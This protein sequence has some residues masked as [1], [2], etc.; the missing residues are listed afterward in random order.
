MADSIYYATTAEGERLSIVDV[1]HPAFAVTVTDDELAVLSDGYVQGLSQRSTLPPQVMEALQRSQL[2]RGLFAASGTY[3]SG[4]ATYL[5][6]LGPDNLPD[7]AEEIDRRLAASFP[8]LMTRLR[9]QDMTQLLVDG[10]TTT[11]RDARDRP[12]ALVNL[13]AGVAA[14][15]WNALIVLRSAGLLEQR[16]VSVVAFDRE[17]AGSMFAGRAFEALRANGAPLAGVDV[18]FRHELYNWSDANR[19]VSLLQDVPASASCA[20]SSEGGLF[21]YASDDDVVA[22]LRVFH[23]CT[24]KETIVV[25]SA[26]REGNLSRAS[27][28]ATGIPTRAR[29]LDAFTAVARDGGWK[30]SRVITRPFSYHL[31]LHKA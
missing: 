28:A 29:S 31:S 19:L 21:E 26:T 16:A 1:T 30:V 6:K 25:G 10:L 5:L 9:L 14:D 18:A 22:N 3:L 7:A 8:A 27:R 17:E 4:I 13:A 15:S 12:L 2:G 20:V 24:P 11:L 23:E